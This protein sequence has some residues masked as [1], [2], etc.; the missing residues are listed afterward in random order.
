MASV[1]VGVEGSVC[2]DDRTVALC[3]GGALV[4]TRVCDLGCVA[5]TCASAPIEGDASV[6]SDGGV[7]SDAGGTRVP[8]GKGGCAATGDARGLAWLFAVA[9]MVRRRRRA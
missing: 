8:T 6:G 4:E 3:T 5:D 2:V 7:P 1:C 9:W